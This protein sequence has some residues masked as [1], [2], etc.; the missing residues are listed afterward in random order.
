[1]RAHTES[2]TAF[3]ADIDFYGISLSEVENTAYSMIDFCEILH[4]AEKD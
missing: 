3:N 1:L 4:H 2:Q